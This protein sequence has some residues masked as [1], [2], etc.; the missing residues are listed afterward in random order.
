M[1]EFSCRHKKGN[2]G[3]KRIVDN[4]EKVEQ[5]KKAVL[6]A[7]HLE[8]LR[9]ARF[10][11]SEDGYWWEIRSGHNGSVRCFGSSGESEDAAWLD[12]ASRIQQIDCPLCAPEPCIGGSHRNAM[13][14]DGVIKPGQPAENLCS[15]IEEVTTAETKGA[16]A[17]NYICDREVL[18]TWVCFANGRTVSLAMGAGHPYLNIGWEQDGER[19]LRQAAAAEDDAGSINIGDQRTAEDLSKVVTSASDQDEFEV[20]LATYDKSLVSPRGGRRSSMKIVAKAAWNAARA[21]GKEMP[22]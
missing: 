4:Q 20:W 16:P 1:V 9:S 8:D 18:P 10:S 22:K 3:G 5:A 15:G 6:T 17:S 14:E 7:W 13:I 12:A 21:Q 19:W 2:T 11:T